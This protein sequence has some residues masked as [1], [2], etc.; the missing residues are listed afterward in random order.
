MFGKWGEEKIPIYQ[1][2]GEERCS[3]LSVKG[4]KKTVVSGISEFAGGGRT[5]EGVLVGKSL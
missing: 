2:K 1:E 4:K 5:R 3:T